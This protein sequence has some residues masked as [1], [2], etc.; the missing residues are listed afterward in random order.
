MGGWASARSTTWTALVL[1]NTDAD[2]CRIVLVPG[3]AG[4]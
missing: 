3:G 1:L 2:R 4:A